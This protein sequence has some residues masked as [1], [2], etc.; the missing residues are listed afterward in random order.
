MRSSLTVPLAAALSLAAASPLAP[1][2]APSRPAAAPAAAI[3]ALRWRHIG[4]FRAGRTK[5]GVGVPSRPGLFYV[6]VVNGGVWRTTDY[7][8]TWQPIF[9]AAATGSVGAIAVAPS[10]PDVLYVGS[11]E[12]MQRPDLSIGDGLYRSAD[13][14][15]TWTHLGL[16]D[17]QQITQVVVDPRNPDR[18]FVA[19]LGHPYGPN[20]ER[21]IFRSTDGGRTFERVLYRDPQTGAADLVMDPV[22]PDVL[23]AVLWESQH[24]PWENGTFTGPGSGLHKSTDG[25]TTWTKVGQGL[26]TYEGDG[27]GRI[28]ITVAPSLPSRLYATVEARRGAGIWRSDDAGLSWRQ[29]NADPRVVA[30]P[31]DAAEVR[32]HPTNPDVVIVPTIVTWK[33]TDGGATFTAIRGA[34]GGDDYQRVWIH[35]TQPD[36]MLLTSDQGAIVTVNGGRTWSSWYNQGTA[37]FYHVS[38]DNAYPYR[39]CGGQQESGSA[40]VRSRGDWG[41]ITMR[42]WTPVGVEEYGYVA[43]DPLDPDVVYGGKVTR[44][45]RRTNRVQ[46]VPPRAL[47]DTGYRVLRTAPVLFSPTNPRRL[48]FASNRVWSSTTG[49]QSWTVMS[50]DLTR[51]DSAVPPS[52]AAYASRPEAGRRHRGVVYTV[53]PSP[54]D[55]AVIWAGTDDGLVHVTRDFGK[56]WTDVTPPDLAPWAKVSLIEASHVD[57]GTAYAAVNTLRLDDNRPHLWRTRDFGRTW[58]EIVAGITPDAATNAIREDPVRRG[59][60]FAGTE[61]T[62]WVSFDDGD[63][64]TSL[65][66][67]LPATSIR[68]L[69]VKDD[70]LVVGTHGRGFWILDDLTPLRDRTELAAQPAHLFAPQRATRVRD[71]MNPDTP[72]PPDEPTADN[73]P[74]GAVLHYWL[75]TDVARVTITIADASGRT[76]AA[77]DSDAAPAPPLEGRNI[78]D[79][80]IRPPQRIPT[81]R[82]VHRVVW[83]LHEAATRLRQSYPISA[84]PA[85]TVPSPAGPWALPGRYTVTLQAGGIVRTAPL[86]VRMDPRVTATPAD[87]AAQHALARQLADAIAK[88]GARLDALPAGA[89]ER[90]TLTRRSSDLHSLYDAVE[91]TDARPTPDVRRTAAELLRTI[92]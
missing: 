32:V 41:R 23:Y 53:A 15:A 91:S 87:L 6:G 12:G 38:A 49:G 81:T 75:G 89:A 4:P 11:G 66:R 7:G 88:V 61:R 51:R 82:G 24:A 73:P 31:G 18:L 71:N 59:L 43:P 77:L 33:S 54:V 17:A 63:S 92:P 74:D 9:D 27:L 25:G 3:E 20:P 5:A 58:T 2:A 70:D 83:D 62:V 84:A 39:V 21:G 10:N 76:V 80:W 48:F 13:G 1:Q 67:N 56:T 35:P 65:R 69:V 37:Q 19:A 29:V 64:W 78:P 52:V 60:L 36:V 44:W 86:V 45:D 55:S 22:N 85:N 30:R 47:R 8:R 90:A 68:D 57:R 72:L 26:P 34:P 40:C 46:A 28:G 16:R 42:D 14:G 79:Y 50:P